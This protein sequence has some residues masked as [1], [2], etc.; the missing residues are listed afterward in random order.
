MDT[1]SLQGTD[2]LEQV[3]NDDIVNNAALRLGS[4]P[5]FWGRYFSGVD[6][7][8]S[9][10][11]FHT[12]ENSTLK[13]HN[14]RVL[15]VGRYTTRVSGDR[16]TGKQDGFDQANDFLQTFGEAYL[17]TQGG[18]FYFFLDVEPNP[19]LSKDYYLGWAVA[20]AGISANLKLLPCVY[21]NA[22]DQSTSEAL[23][24]AISAGAEC[25]GLWIAAYG[26]NH[27]P[28]LDWDS[29]I[30]RPETPVSCPVLLW[31]YAG[32]VGD[33]DFNLSHPGFLT[34]LMK[35]RYCQ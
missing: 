1:R 31:Q 33:Y 13:R 12:Q 25:H 35:N 3:T 32:D 9:G 34:N 30:A 19:P 14:I 29:S 21:L 22:G 27:V 10:E 4:K 2:T 7:K 24:A 17:I 15:P 11:Y 8:G 23:N 26:N 5:A 16:S 6:Y 28:I 20:V 18:E